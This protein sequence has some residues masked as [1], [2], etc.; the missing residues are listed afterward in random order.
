MLLTIRDAK[1]TLVAKLDENWYTKTVVQELL[2]KANGTW[3]TFPSG[4]KWYVLDDD[5]SFNAIG[6]KLYLWKGYAI[7]VTL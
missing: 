4:N 6:L 5:Y 3:K 1:G 2:H 7:N